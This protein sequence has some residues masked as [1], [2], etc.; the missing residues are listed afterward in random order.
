MEPVRELARVLKTSGLSHLEPT[1]AQILLTELYDKAFQ[2]NQHADPRRPIS[3]VAMNPKE[4]YSVQGRR[5]SLF[6]QFSM[7]GIG[8]KFN[9]SITDFLKCGR[10]DV[11]RMVRIAEEDHANKVKKEQELA[12]KMSQLEQGR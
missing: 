12:S 1:A 11:D 7:F 5:E 9:I 4:N 3:L 6:R 8:E 10:D 2:I